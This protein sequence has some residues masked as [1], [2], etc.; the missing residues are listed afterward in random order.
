M[1]IDK[2]IDEQ[3]DEAFSYEWLSKKWKNIFETPEE[4]Y[5][6]H[7]FPISFSR[8]AF[9]FNPKYLTTSQF[10]KTEQQSPTEGNNLESNSNIIYI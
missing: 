10:I 3:Y 1:K 8:Y 9:D 6:R 4:Q 5:K 2:F 7:I